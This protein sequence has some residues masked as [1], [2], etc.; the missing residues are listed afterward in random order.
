MKYYHSSKTQLPIGDCL[1][2]KTGRDDGNILKGGAVFMTSDI[3]S[4]R[5]YGSF[6]YEIECKN[7]VPYKVALKAVGR[8]KKPRYTR[9]VFIACPIKTIII[10]EL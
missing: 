4:C 10:K 5:R 7:P 2:T 3:K 6:V 9:N 8:S 1:R